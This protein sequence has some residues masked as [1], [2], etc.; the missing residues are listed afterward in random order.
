MD[1]K[2]HRLAIYMITTT[3]PYDIATFVSYSYNYSI[4]LKEDLSY[5]DCKITIRLYFEVMKAF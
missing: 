3:A 5:N 1:D 4:Y 2:L